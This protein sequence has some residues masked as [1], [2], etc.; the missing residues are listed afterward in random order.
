M[1]PKCPL[2]HQR[3]LTRPSANTK[4]LVTA[5]LGLWAKLLHGLSFSPLTADPLC[6]EM[7]NADPARVSSFLS[8]ASSLCMNTASKEGLE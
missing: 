4:V 2:E 1:L 3:Q 7:L 8:L 6:L 5:A